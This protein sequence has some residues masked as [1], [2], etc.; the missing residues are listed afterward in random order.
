VPKITYIQPDGEEKTVDVPV[1]R[2]VMEGAIENDI[3]G[4]VAACGG[5]CSCST[6]HVHVDEVWMDSVG[7]PHDAEQDTLEFAV[8]VDESSRLSC[9]IEVTRD[10]DG[11][12]V[13]VADEQA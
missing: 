4:I 6:C 7:P 12:I 10:L 11:L 3:D 8:D 1:G 2:T 13:R 9:Q 5:S